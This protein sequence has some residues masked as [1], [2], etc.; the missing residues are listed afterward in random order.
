MF[1]CVSLFEVV[2]PGWQ[3]MGVSIVNQRES[4]RNLSATRRR[5]LDTSG[6]R[7]RSW[8]V[9]AGRAYFGSPGA[10]IDRRDS[11]LSDPL[12]YYT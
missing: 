1:E 3:A 9:R 11:W 7:R 8:G 2:R 10:Q 4:L 12:P 5:L 6:V